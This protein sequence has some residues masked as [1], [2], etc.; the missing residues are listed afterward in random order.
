MSV[1]LSK[2]S[3]RMIKMFSSNYI[4]VT[5]VSHINTTTVFK[6][7]IPY[8]FSHFDLLPFSRD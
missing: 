6:L 8:I 3:H 7:G 2:K 5:I 4:P 1:S